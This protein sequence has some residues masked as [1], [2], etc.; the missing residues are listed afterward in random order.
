MDPALRDKLCN[1]RAE[2]AV[3]GWGLKGKASDLIKV[4]EKDFNHPPNQ[5]IYKA[6]TKMFT[7]GRQIDP[8]TVADELES[9]GQLDSSGGVMYLTALEDGVY[10]FQGFDEYVEILKE[11]TGARELFA[12]SQSIPASLLGGKAVSDITTSLMSKLIDASSLSESGLRPIREAMNDT[13]NAIAVPVNERRLIRTGFPTLDDMLGGLRPQTMHVI[14]GRA[15]MG[16]TAFAL[17]MAYNMARTGSKVAVFSLEMSSI[18]IS[19]RL[20]SSLSGYSS[21]DLQTK[22]GTR[23]IDTEKVL[24]AIQGLYTLDFYIDDG[25]LSTVPEILAKCKTMKATQ[26]LDVVVIDYINLME[27][28]TKSGNRVAEVSEM[29]RHLKLMAKE[30]DI[31]VV[32]LSQTNRGVEAR[33]NKRPVLSDLRESGSIEQ[34][35]DSVMFLYREG[36]YEDSKEAMSFG[37]DAELLV[38][39]NRHGRTGTVE[40]TWVP[41]LTTFIEKDMSMAQMREVYLDEYEP[42]TRYDSENYEI[43]EGA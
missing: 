23:H 38:R 10:G 29:T 8:L 25:G 5:R 18:E 15:G 32:A 11:K 26:G 12:V 3:L 28:S 40:L 9:Q 2:Q 1:D 36:Y 16:K 27:P 31:P 42:Q 13:L 17:N 24:K 35:A 19:L 20:L 6:I 41:N 4:D 37:E 30:L 39:K 21:Q 22:F 34:D 43:A 14:S 33:D 7:E